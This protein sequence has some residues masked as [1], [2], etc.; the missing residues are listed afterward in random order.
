MSMAISRAPRTAR[1]TRLREDSDP[2]THA[3]FT[4]G[5]VSMGSGSSIQSLPAVQSVYSWT[6]SVRHEQAVCTRLDYR[7]HG[8]VTGDRWLAASD[9]APRLL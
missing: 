8:D 4:P 1:R 3:G 2:G 9:A 6:R 7:P 5:R